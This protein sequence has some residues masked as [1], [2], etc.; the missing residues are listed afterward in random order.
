M[1]RPEGVSRRDPSEEVNRE[2]GDPRG[3]G[4]MRGKSAGA[5]KEL[6]EAGWRGATPR[7]REAAARKEG[8]ADEREPAPEARAP[9][10]KSL[11]ALPTSS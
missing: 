6:Q 9:Q 2:G 8:K 7:G 1:A 11:E 10:N 5:S 4:H 3:V